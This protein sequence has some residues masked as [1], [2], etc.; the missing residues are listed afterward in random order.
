[1]QS[2]TGD[3]LQEEIPLFGVVGAMFAVVQRMEG[4]EALNMQSVAL[5]CDAGAPERC[6][7]SGSTSTI[8]KCPALIKRPSS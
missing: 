2:D 4:V 5:R 3:L 7:C 8:V 6:R 1:M